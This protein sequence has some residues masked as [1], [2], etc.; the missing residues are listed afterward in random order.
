MLPSSSRPGHPSRIV[1]SGHQAQCV[2]SAISL[3]TLHVG[4]PCRPPTIAWPELCFLHPNPN[5]NQPSRHHGELS[6]QQHDDGHKNFLCAPY[7]TSL[8]L[9]ARRLRLQASI[10]YTGTCMTQCISNRM[11][12]DNGSM[13]Q[14]HPQPSDMG[15]GP[16]CHHLALASEAFV[17]GRQPQM[18]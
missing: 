13:S 8:W 4:L 17:T 7:C 9:F 12:W 11:V 18:H 3:L 6:T 1:G 5:P 2:A 14:C 15:W 10:G 16:P